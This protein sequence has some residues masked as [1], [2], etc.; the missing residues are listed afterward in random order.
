MCFLGVQT[1]Y[2][3]RTMKKKLLSSL[4]LGSISS[5]LFAQEQLPEEQV[6][7]SIG[8]KVNGLFEPIVGFLAQVFFW[9]PVKAVGLDIGADVPIIVVWLVIG[10]IYFTFKM[11]FI[12]IRG[13]K[14]SIDL[15]QGKYDD[16]NDKGEVS[17][18]QALTTALSVSA[19]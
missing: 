11:K 5:V 4:I 17:H 9:D 15:V 13:F 6:A 2:K 18:F 16:P 19:L 3:S 8:D 14:H 7:E 10:A 12:N 1:T